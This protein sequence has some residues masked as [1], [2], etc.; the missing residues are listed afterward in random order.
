MSNDSDYVDDLNYVHI[1]LHSFL[2]I[3]VSNRLRRTYVIQD[4]T[5]VLT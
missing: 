2:D 4:E 3:K 5:D 1:P